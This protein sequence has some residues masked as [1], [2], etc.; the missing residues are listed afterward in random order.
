[1]GCGLSRHQQW[2]HDTD[3]PTAITCY[4]EAKVITTSHFS[5]PVPGESE[6]IHAYPIPS[7]TL[8]FTTGYQRLQLSDSC[9]L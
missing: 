5:P 8:T 4:Q 6:E 1:M 9:R 2:M 7:P 3:S